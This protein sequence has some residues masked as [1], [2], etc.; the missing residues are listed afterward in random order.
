M[1]LKSLENRFREGGRAFGRG[2]QW[3]LG[4]R[5]C[6]KRITIDIFFDFLIIVWYR[7]T[8]IQFELF[9]ICFLTK[10]HHLSQC[11]LGH[12][13]LQSIT[14]SGEWLYSFVQVVRVNYTSCQY[15]IIWFGNFPRSD[16]FEITS[17]CHLK[18]ISIKF[19]TI[20]NPCSTGLSELR[21]ALGGG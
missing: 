13:V 21:Y 2:C 15:G 9:L 18:N 16:L 20:F 4:C 11:L 10:D 14:C 3:H 19:A 5:D 1:E 12:Q 6:P 17:S 7:K 8:K